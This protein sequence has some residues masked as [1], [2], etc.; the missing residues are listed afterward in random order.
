M[1]FKQEIS[2]VL[3]HHGAKDV[4]LEVPPEGMGD[5]AFPCFL[6]REHFKKNPAEIAAYLSQKI[7]L[8]FLEKIEA[9]GPYLNFF[10]KRQALAQQALAAGISPVK[11]RGKTVMI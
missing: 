9:K 10:I 1:D 11:K 7:R 3:E 2:K 4:H 6:L 8:P 5:F